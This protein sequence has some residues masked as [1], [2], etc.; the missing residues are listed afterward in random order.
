MPTMHLGALDVTSPAFEH[1]GAIP[2]VHTC[3]GDDTSPPL[4]WSAVPEGTEELVVICHDPDAPLTW[5]FT[6]WVLYG[7]TPD[8]GGIP[9]GETGGGTLGANEMGDAAYMGPAPPPGHGPHHYFFHVF[10]L[11]AP[12]GLEP[13]AGREEVLQRIDELIIEQARLVG[14]YE[15]TPE[16]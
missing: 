2:A 1:G 11:S 12:S 5:G 7:L 8:I 14:T 9:E 10:A 4:Q 6:H 16:A 15:R 3:E 13:G